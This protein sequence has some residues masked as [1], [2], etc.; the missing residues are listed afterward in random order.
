MGT[1]GNIRIHNGNQD[2]SVYLYSHWDSD[3]A[4]P[5]AVKTA[6]TRAVSR[7]DD[8]T[9]LARVIFTD[10]IRDDINSVTGYGIAAS[11]KDVD[12]QDLI[13]DVDCQAQAVTYEGAWDDLSGTSLTFQEFVS[14]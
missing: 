14:S 13:L 2:R 5:T 12:G 9:Y 10:L 11:P 6:L 8:P 7:W 4:L 1:R 3:T